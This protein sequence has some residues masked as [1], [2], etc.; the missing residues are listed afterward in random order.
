MGSPGQRDL[1]AP[2]GGDW[3]SGHATLLASRHALRGLSDTGLRSSEVG[4]AGCGNRCSL[5]GSV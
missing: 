3:P 4:I 2:K 1:A 5:Q